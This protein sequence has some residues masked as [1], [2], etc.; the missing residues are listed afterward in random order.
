MTRV[1][2]YLEKAFNVLFSRSS[3]RTTQHGI[4]ADT[5]SEGAHFSSRSTQSGVSTYAAYEAE[6]IEKMPGCVLP[7]ELKANVDP[8]IGP[9]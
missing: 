8:H 9:E 3:D 4:Y 7:R 1:T 2:G 5:R 6:T